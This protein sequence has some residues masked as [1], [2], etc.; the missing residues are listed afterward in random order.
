MMIKLCEHCLVEFYGHGNKRYCTQECYTDAN[1]TRNRD[2]YWCDGRDRIY[3]SWPADVVQK[4]YEVWYAYGLYLQEYEEMM[5]LGCAICGAEA[6]DL[7]HD[8]ET[9]KVREALC[10]GCNIRISFAN[11]EDIRTLEDKIELI[12]KDI[13][14]L[15]KHR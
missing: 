6:T 8:H 4:E 1:R 15:E 13:S 3:A 7:D 9:G 11:E 5:A 14:Y 2:K 12:R 10:R